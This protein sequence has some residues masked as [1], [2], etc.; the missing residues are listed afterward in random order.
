MYSSIGVGWCQSL[1]PIMIAFFN[2]AILTWAL[3]YSAMSLTQVELPWTGCHHDWN[4]VHCRDVYPDFETVD[5]NRTDLR[6]GAEYFR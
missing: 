2:N 5:V 1:L 3:F 4:T 6:A